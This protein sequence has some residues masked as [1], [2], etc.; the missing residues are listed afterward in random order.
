[1][2]SSPESWNGLVM[3]IIN[4]VSIYSTLK[5]DDVT[6]T[7]LSEEIRW[8][9]SGETLS[10]SLTIET[11]GGMERGRSPINHSKSRKD[12]SKSRSGIMCSKCG[13]KGHLK[14]YCKYQKGKEGDG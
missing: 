11:R 5:F 8:K 1:M 12:R 13:K 3:A 9:S 10:N 14:K 2:C 6:G 7:I 4:S